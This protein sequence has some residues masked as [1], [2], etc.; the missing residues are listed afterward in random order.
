MREI[1]SKPKDLLKLIKDNPDLPVVPMVDAEIAGDDYGY[2]LGSWGRCEVTELYLG[3]EKIHFKDD[4]EEDVLVDMI[5]CQYGMDREGRDI[6]ELSDD[7]WHEIF[8]DLPW[9]KVIVVYITL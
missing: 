4:D 3:R 9:K 1:M 2:W 5:G 6:F 7:D 8:N